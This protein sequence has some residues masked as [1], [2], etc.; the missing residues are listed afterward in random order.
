MD[1]A[2]TLE[3]KARAA[4]VK[5][6]LPVDHVTAE[7]EATT[8]SGTTPGEAVPMGMAGYDIGPR[9]AEIFGS[10]ISGAKTILWNGPVGRFEVEGFAAGTRNVASAIAAATSRGGL[11]VVGGGDSAAALKALGM[12]Q[13]FSHISTGGGASLEFLSGRELPGVAALADA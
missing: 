6:L 11:S 7:P 2:R 12:E 1:L 13:Q 8:P 3:K 9:T 5:L 10:E 4:G